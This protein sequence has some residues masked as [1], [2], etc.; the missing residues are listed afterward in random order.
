MDLKLSVVEHRIVVMLSGRPSSDVS[1][2]K[3]RIL[4]SEH[5]FGENFC[6]SFKINTPTTLEPCYTLYEPV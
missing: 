2:F 1:P 6:F 5:S 4:M 3:F